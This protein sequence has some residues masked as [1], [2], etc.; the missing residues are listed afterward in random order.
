MM[1]FCVDGGWCAV[2][3]QDNRNSGVM[4]IV[5]LVR[6]LQTILAHMAM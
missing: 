5:D 6:R 3:H 1:Y 2:S 4:S